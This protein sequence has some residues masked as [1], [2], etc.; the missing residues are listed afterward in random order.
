MHRPLLSG[1][2]CIKTGCPVMLHL[3]TQTCRQD[4]NNTAQHASCCHLL[5]MRRPL[6]CSNITFHDRKGCC[7]SL[8]VRVV[9]AIVAEA[10][11]SPSTSQKAAIAAL[12]ATL[13]TASRGRGAAAWSSGCV[14]DHATHLPTSIACT[15][16]RHTMFKVAQ[17]CLSC[18]KGTAVVPMGTPA[19]PLHCN[20]K[21]GI[22]SH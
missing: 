12:P 21:K 5:T 4:E 11:K 14:T 7:V 2:S 9:R 15:A 19:A 16:A 18:K 8:T 10:A 1:L 20:W 22:E 13:S 3:Q 6:P 17:Q